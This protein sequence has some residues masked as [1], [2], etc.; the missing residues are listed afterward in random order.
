M[1]DCN[2]RWYALHVLK[3][4]QFFKI[5]SYNWVACFLKHPVVGSIP[6]DSS[7]PKQSVTAKSIRHLLKLFKRCSVAKR[8]PYNMSIF[9]NNFGIVNFPKGMLEIIKKS[10]K[11]GT[12]LEPFQIFKALKSMC[13]FRL[14]IGN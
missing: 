10:S 8:L 9:C 13:Y 5:S 2:F 11:T 4:W 1:K 14:G 3:F 6:G 12:D 7:D